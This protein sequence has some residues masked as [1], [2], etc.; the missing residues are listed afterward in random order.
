MTGTVHRPLEPADPT[1]SVSFKSVL[2][3]VLVMIAVIVGAF[4]I[5]AY[6]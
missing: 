3:V 2:V 1:Y 6:A 4:L 5:L